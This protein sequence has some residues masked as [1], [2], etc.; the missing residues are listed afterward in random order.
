MSMK[1]QSS[2]VAFKAIQEHT[3]GVNLVSPPLTPPS[4]HSTLASFS[5]VG[6]LKRMASSDLQEVNKRF[7]SESAS[8]SPQNPHPFTLPPLSR[9]N[10]TLPQPI[11]PRL[12]TKH[13]SSDDYLRKVLEPAPPAKLIEFGSYYLPTFNPDTGMTCSIYRQ[14]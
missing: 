3:D 12:I 1:T 9:Y 7:K 10:S 2:I 11:E 5:P 8:V 6:S 14:L 13:V 4:N